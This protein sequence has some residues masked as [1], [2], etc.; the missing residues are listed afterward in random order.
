MH[1]VCVCVQMFNEPEIR[2][3]ETAEM[4]LCKWIFPMYVMEKNW[5]NPH[6]LSFT[7]AGVESLPAGDLAT[8]GSHCLGLRNC[9]PLVN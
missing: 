9:Y 7:P 1:S 3:S 8:F 2:N 5:F 6:V 4:M